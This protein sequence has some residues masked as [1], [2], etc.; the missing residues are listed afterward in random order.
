MDEHVEISYHNCKKKFNLGLHACFTNKRIV[1]NR[2][3]Y[4]AEMRSLLEERKAV[5]K[6]LQVSKSSY[7]YRQTIAKMYKFDRKIEHKIAY[8]NSLII[9]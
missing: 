8:F 9:R 3:P 4:N 6:K 1:P 2:R 5:K 7:L